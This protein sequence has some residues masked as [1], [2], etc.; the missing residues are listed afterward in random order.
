[1]FDKLAQ[2]YFS[3]EEQYAEGLELLQ[4]YLE[5]ASTCHDF[6]ELQTN[7]LDRLDDSSD[8]TGLLDSALRFTKAPDISN[9]LH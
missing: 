3:T 5:A 6:D 7:F 4:Q 1:M 9:L 2:R 8:E